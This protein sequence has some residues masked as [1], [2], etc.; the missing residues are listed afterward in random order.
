[1]TLRR[2]INLASLTFAAALFAG[3]ADAREVLPATMP[4]ADARP[5]ELLS[6]ATTRPGE[7]R[8]IR[9]AIY[10]GT[11]GRPLGDGEGNLARCLA[12]GGQFDLRLVTAEQIKG[13]VLDEVDV[14]VQAGCGNG[15]GQAKSLEAGGRDAIRTF[16]G[17]GGGYV[18]IC[19][20][21]Y[22]ATSEYP[23]SLHIL[24]ARLVDRAHWAR[25]KGTVE[26][27][28]NEAGRS[29]LNVHNA[30]LPMRFVQGPLF[31][32][33]GDVGLPDY[34][35]LAKFEDEISE[36]GAPANQM[37]GATAAVAA[38]Y[39]KGRVICLSTHPELTAGY[40][41]IVRRAVSWAARRVVD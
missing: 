40:D 14:L 7:T 34:E 6:S 21:A 19:A 26:V 36:N 33:A 8:A 13:G 24:N 31:V 37:T 18:G 2:A 15:G 9:V 5:P 38:R 17:R 29:L 16:I 10:N 1:M 28:F 35:S 20:G 12:A 23:W 3:F 22:L 25:G 30:T 4:A 41:G 27:E 39:D 32:P 11:G